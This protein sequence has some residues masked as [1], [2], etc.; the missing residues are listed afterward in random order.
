MAELV[1]YGQLIQIH[2]YFSGLLGKP[3]KY[4]ANPELRDDLLDSSVNRM[5][6]SS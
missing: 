3:Y 4:P 1:Y 6:L 2:Q 5:A